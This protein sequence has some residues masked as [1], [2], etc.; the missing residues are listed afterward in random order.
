MRSSVGDKHMANLRA[1]T[2]RFFLYGQGQLATKWQPPTS[3]I[4]SVDFNEFED[5]R[6]FTPLGFDGFETVRIRAPTVAVATA[7]RIPCSETLRLAQDMRTLYSGVCE[8]VHRG[9]IIFEMVNG[10]W[11]VPFDMINVISKLLQVAPTIPV[12]LHIGFDLD[13]ILSKVTMRRISLRTVDLS[14]LSLSQDLREYFC[15][16]I[17]K[18]KNLETV[19][20]AVNLLVR[21]CRAQLQ[22]CVADM[23]SVSN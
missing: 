11:D 18:H 5:L 12:K 4:E 17:L 14:G 3:D 6:P 8:D 1:D 10:D 2:F 16:P 19:M 23:V 20:M 13:M 15:Q 7:P 22:M 21:S 9:R